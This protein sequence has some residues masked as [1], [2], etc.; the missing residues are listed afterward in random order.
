MALTCPRCSVLMTEQSAITAEGP[1]VVVDICPSCK[2][3]WL[4]AQ[5]LEAVCPTVAD[6][7]ARKTEILLVG[8]AGMNIPSCPRCQAVPYEFAIME[9]MLIDFCPQCSGVWLDGDEYEEGAF[10]PLADADRPRERS[11]YRA[12]ADKAE[13]KREVTCQDCARSVTVA[14]SYVWEYGFICKACFTAKEQRAS[15][16]RVAETDQSL[17]RVIGDV[18]SWILPVIDSKPGGLH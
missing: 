17:G 16:R 14:T 5:K 1:A 3:L 9:D 4:D 10:E 11:P 13:K 6:L 8:Q 12:A 15:N 7:P 2:G 18:L